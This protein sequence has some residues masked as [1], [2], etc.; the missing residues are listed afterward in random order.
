MPSSRAA[1]PPWP[2]GCSPATAC[3]SR[4]RLKC[5]RRPGVRSPTGTAT[6][7][8]RC[9]IPGAALKI[10]PGGIDRAELQPPDRR[11]LRC[12]A[13]GRRA[14]GGGGAAGARA[15][16]DAAG[17]EGPWRA[18]AAAASARRDHASTRLP[19]AARTTPGATPS[20]RSP[21]SATRCRAGLLAL[22][23]RARP[24]RTGREPTCAC[25]LSGQMVPWSIFRLTAGTADQSV[26]NAR[27]EMPKDD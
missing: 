6:A 2:R 19:R 1:I 9:S 25:R 27:K 11:P 3:G 23:A 14:G 7:C 8:R 10:F 22:G 4:G 5:W 13:G 17:D 20:A 18:V 24:R 26:Y 15:R 12:H 16:P 21:G